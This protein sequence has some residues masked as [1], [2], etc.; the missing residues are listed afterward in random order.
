RAHIGTHI[1]RFIRRVNETLRAPIGS[2]LPCG[3]CAASG[4]PECQVH[5]R[6]KAQVTHVECE[7]SMR[8]AFNYKPADQGSKTTPCRNVPVICKLCF[9]DAP[10]PDASQPAQW[11]YN[12][13][14]HLNI[15]HPEYA[16]PLNPGG[17]RLPH[18]VW[19]S[20]EVDAKEEMA[21]GIPSTSIPA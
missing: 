10:R 7:C 8:S 9:P 21:L 6:K 14:E 12:M 3:F 15:A 11:R 1:L 13:P 5:L 16:S 20:M 19:V 2:S 18:E 4:K 17:T